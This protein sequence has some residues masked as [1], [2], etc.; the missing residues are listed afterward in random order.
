MG[1]PPLGRYL[2]YFPFPNL[3]RLLQRLQDA[4]SSPLHLDR[5]TRQKGRNVWGRE[6]MK[7]LFNL[8]QRPVGP[9]E[10]L[11]AGYRFGQGASPVPIL[12]CDGK[13]AQHY[14]LQVAA[15]RQTTPIILGPRRSVE[16]L[17]ESKSRS[18]DQ[19]LTDAAAFDFDTWFDEARANWAELSREFDGLEIPPR[20]AKTGPI[21]TPDA[22]EIA[23]WDPV[24]GS[25]VRNLHI[26]LFPTADPTVVPAVFDFGGWNECPPSEVHVALHR[27]WRDRY[28]ARLI[29]M[30][31]D[32][33]TFHVTRPPMTFNEALDLAREHY[34]Y[35]NDTIDQGF[36][37]LDAL[38]SALVAAQTWCFWWD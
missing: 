15:D 35:C 21:D 14:V 6:N 19:I 33:L 38:A 4:L 1:K 34:A 31:F 25:P 26:G 32:T 11:D 27:S 8:F 24:L 37:S 16:L 3:T 22:I 29:N 9:S 36:E 5:E 30:G 12:V 18:A 28:G 13:D 17:C 2:S 20:G 10:T 23:S 7:K